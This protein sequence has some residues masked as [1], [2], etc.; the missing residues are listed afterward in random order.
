MAFLGGHIKGKGFFARSE[1]IFE[2]TLE[3]VY[4][5]A[6]VEVSGRPAVYYIL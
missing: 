5:K 6:R 4:V 2:V 1:L 3:L